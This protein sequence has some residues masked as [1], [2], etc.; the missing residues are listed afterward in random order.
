MNSAI[1]EFAA[2][3]D[4]LADDLA[5]CIA[6]ELREAG[7]TD[8]A[9]ITESD[10]GRVHTG[11][12][13]FTGPALRSLYA[14]EIGTR[15]A[16]QGPAIFVADWS[17]AAA[18]SKAK[19]AV[20]MMIATAVH[21]T[22]HV[23]QGPIRCVAVAPENY[24][25]SQEY[26]ARQLAAEPDPSL[27]FSI[28]NHD[29]DFVRSAVHLASRLT[30]RGWAI[31]P[32]Q[33]WDPAV[34]G[35]AYGRPYRGAMN[36]ELKHSATLPLSAIL[37]LTPSKECVLLYEYDRRHI[38]ESAKMNFLDSLKTKQQQKKESAAESFSRFVISVADGKPPTEDEILDVIRELDRT[39]ADFESA[40]EALAERRKLKA[41]IDRRGEIQAQLDSAQAEFFSTQEEFLSRQQTF[42]EVANVFIEKRDRF[43]RE[44]LECDNA[45]RLLRETAPQA[46][47]DEYPPIGKELVRVQERLVYV[48]ESLYVAQYNLRLAES[49]AARQEHSAGV[50]A[51]LDAQLNH[52]QA[53]VENRE[54]QIR[55]LED[56]Q[57]ELRARQAE[58]ERR[59]FHV[60]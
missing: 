16:A 36:Q 39:V 20:G 47:H 11:V 23:L 1:D 25:A 2:L 18:F 17:I 50:R 42:T 7:F 21:E 43:N 30:A 22:A 59:L 46:L 54:G 13:G 6:P 40:V 3:R 10:V 26:V 55:Q 38:L 44:L 57:R 56:E 60:D 49:A 52:C 5:D 35:L 24:K 4:R 19:N 58:L 31:D 45:R 9:I 41:Q 29:L 53:E 37:R 12:Y 33:L 14:G 32:D 27:R 28:D 8:L 48:R 51:Q 15:Y 34:A